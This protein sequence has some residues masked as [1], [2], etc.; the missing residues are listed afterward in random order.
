[1]AKFRQ[2]FYLPIVYQ[3]ERYS[4]TRLNTLMIAKQTKLDRQ[5]YAR[6]TQGTPR[7][8]PMASAPLDLEHE[9]KKMWIS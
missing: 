5:D 8:R 9:T 4:I 1:M 2:E 3:I 6:Y 7:V